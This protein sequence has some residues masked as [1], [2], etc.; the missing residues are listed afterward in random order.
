MNNKETRAMRA[1]VRTHMRD[2]R[3]FKTL[4]FRY[5]S[6]HGGR[7]VIDEKE[8]FEVAEG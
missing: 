5:D 7:F 8:F 3:M 4:G 1:R 6:A 2:V